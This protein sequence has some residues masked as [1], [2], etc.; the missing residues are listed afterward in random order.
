MRQ[1]PNAPRSL[2][3]TDA[4]EEEAEV[5]REQ[6]TD[7]S[8]V[9]LTARMRTMLASALPEFGIGSGHYRSRSDGR[10]RNR[11]G[12]TVSRR[13]GAAKTFLLRLRTFPEITS[14]ADLGLSARKSGGNS[15]FGEFIQNF[16]APFVNQSSVQGITKKPSQVL[17]EDLVVVFSALP[18]VGWVS[19][20]NVNKLTKSGK[21]S[22]V[23]PCTSSC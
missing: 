1:F 23:I 17:C 3:W 6:S 12:W 15:F 9:F 21:V 10:P 20:K 2:V 5:G 8:A 13:V 22:L 18:E 16:A 7:E 4:V 14:T 19:A 11:F